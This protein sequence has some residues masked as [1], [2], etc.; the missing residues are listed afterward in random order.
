MEGH[1]ATE[2]G[3]AY[4]PVSQAH[5]HNLYGPLASRKWCV[6]TWVGLS[7]RI[8]TE[9][10]IDTQ[11]V[12][13]EGEGVVGVLGPAQLVPPWTPARVGRAALVGMHYGCPTHVPIGGLTLPPM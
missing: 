2:T 5:G 11:K 13:I 3:L 1:E 12:G 9:K 7:K 4:A 6:G 8:H 10:K